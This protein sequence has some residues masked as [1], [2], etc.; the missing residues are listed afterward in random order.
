[1]NQSMYECRVYD[2]PIRLIYNMETNVW[3]VDESTVENLKLLKPLSKINLYSVVK[4]LTVKQLIQLIKKNALP[5]RASEH[6]ISKKIAMND[7]TK[8][9]SALYEVS[10]AFAKKFDV[11]P[12]MIIFNKKE[13]F[14]IIAQQ[15]LTLYELYCI[16]QRNVICVENNIYNWKL[17]LYNVRLKMNN[18]LIEQPIELSIFI[19]PLYFPHTPPRIY[20]IYPLF[21]NDLSHRIKTS[22]FT[23]LKY[24]NPCR[25]LGQ[26]IERTVERIERYGEVMCNELSENMVTVDNL[27][28]R[29]SSSIDTQSIDPIDNDHQPVLNNLNGSA[30]NNNKDT[31]ISINGSHSGTGYGHATAPKWDVEE[32]NQLKKDN[33]FKLTDIFINLNILV[34]RIFSLTPSVSCESVELGFRS[35]EHKYLYEAIKK[36]CIIGYMISRLN[37][38]TML[39]ISENWKFYA[40]L[41]GLIQRLLVDKIGELFY[42]NYEKN[43]S[44]QTIFIGLA[45][46]ANQSFK[47]EDIAG[48]ISVSTQ[49]ITEIHEQMTEILKRN[50]INNMTE[51][52]HNLDHEQK[53][54]R[55]IDRKDEYVKEM[56]KYKWITYDLINSGYKYKTDTVS[57][58]GSSMRGCMKRLIAETP[59]LADSLSIEWD[60][61]VLFCTD[62]KNLNCMRFLVTGPKDTPYENGILIFDASMT[63]NYPTEA[64]LFHLMNTGGYRLNPNLYA[65]GKVCLSLLGTYIGPKP[66]ESEKWIPQIS[67]LYQVIISIQSQILVEK[68]YFNEPGYFSSMGTP[69]GEM[70]SNDSNE[71][72]R[73]AVMQSTMLDLLENPDTFPEFKEATQQYFKFKR[74]EIMKQLTGWIDRCKSVDILEKMTVLFNR[75]TLLLNAL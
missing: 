25:S 35:R 38:T 49:M 1:M 5:S 50:E 24:W 19:H 40:E 64:P 28:Y 39:D 73:M 17:L 13:I 7:E 72:I 66:D 27:I 21:K 36:S 48:E 75:I 8:K 47:L 71:M 44:I 4:K 11:V 30:P 46:K 68:P 20:I 15:Y 57:Y 61:M 59:S 14:D 62:K 43:M 60:A 22:K 52:V 33:E 34:D 65:D 53:D 67:T 2:A 41:F 55:A 70:R 45:Q 10:I 23:Q 32:F 56:T 29:L 9:I 3:I 26:I 74:S 58:G 51:H 37:Q 54:N 6:N 18:Q 31:K 12:D 63:P 42:V 16:D 69:T